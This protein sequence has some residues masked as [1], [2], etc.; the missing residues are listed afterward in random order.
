MY[1]QKN[2][3]AL[4][5]LLIKLATKEKVFGFDFLVWS[6]YVGNGET[7]NGKVNVTVTGKTC[8]RWDR[9]SP[10]THSYMPNLY[11]NLA[12]NYCRN[13][14]D[15]NQPWCYTTDSQTRWESCP[16][17]QCRK[18]HLS[19]FSH[20]TTI[21]HQITNYSTLNFWIWLLRETQN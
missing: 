20:F 2:L 15:W 12:E 6:C 11:P 16:L 10:H 8:Q 5:Q 17:T 14:S 21:I 13:P 9:Q 3:R 18:L 19:S 7:Y 4:G 1:R